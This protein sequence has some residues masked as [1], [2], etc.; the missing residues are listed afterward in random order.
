MLEFVNAWERE[1]KMGDRYFVTRDSISGYFTDS[2]TSTPRP[3]TRA[4]TPRSAPGIESAKT[5]SASDT[6]PYSTSTAR[7]VVKKYSLKR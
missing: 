7:V 6:P 4:S 1:Q 3:D 2:P 5:A